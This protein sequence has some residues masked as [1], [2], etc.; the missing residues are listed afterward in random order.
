MFTKDLTAV[1][2]MG[3]SILAGYLQDKCWLYRT[4][5][6]SGGGAEV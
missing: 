1:H 5:S 4:N 3:V 6:I 2:I